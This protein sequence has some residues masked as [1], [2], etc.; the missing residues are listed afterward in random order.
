MQF[1]TLLAQAGELTTQTGDRE[2]VEVILDVVRLVPSPWREILMAALAMTWV[3]RKNISIAAREGWEHLLDRWRSEEEKSRRR[4]KKVAERER[5]L[6]E[7]RAREEKSVERMLGK[8]VDDLKAE[9]A[10]WKT[11]ALALLAG[12]EPAEIWRSQIIQRE[13]RSTN[14]NLPAKTLEELSETSEEIE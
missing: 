10:F 14:P 12:G 4:E 11:G 13:L 3:Y 2:A 7:K 1:F 8:Q 9:V 6:A 5:K